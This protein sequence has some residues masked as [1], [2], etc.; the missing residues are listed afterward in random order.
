MH[1]YTNKYRRKLEANTR[2]CPPQETSTFLKDS[3][4][5]NEILPI[6]C[7]LAG[8]PQGSSW[9]CLREWGGGRGKGEDEDEGRGGMRV[10]GYIYIPPYS[11]FFKR[12]F[13]YFKRYICGSYMCECTQ[14]RSPGAEVSDS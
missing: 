4:S 5:L 8:Q 3:V 13:T 11:V 1:A 12:G 7:S 9:L 10:L 6:F 2:C 14:V